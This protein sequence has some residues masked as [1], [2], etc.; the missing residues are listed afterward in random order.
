MRISSLMWRNRANESFARV[1]LDATQ[2]HLYQEMVAQLLVLL[3]RRFATMSGCNSI[4][5]RCTSLGTIFD[6]V[7]VL[8]PLFTPGERSPTDHT[9]FLGQFRPFVCHQ[10]CSLAACNARIRSARFLGW[11]DFADF[12]LRFLDVA[13]LLPSA[14]WIA[15]S[16]PSSEAVIAVT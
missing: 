10:A 12:E 5:L 9:V 15:E 1:L 11:S 7:P 14:L 3:A 4:A 2:I 6:F 16:G 8:F 13:L